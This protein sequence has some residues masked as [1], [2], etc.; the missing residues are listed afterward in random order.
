MT[1]EDLEVI[2]GEKKVSLYKEKIWKNLFLYIYI[3]FFLVGN[4]SKIQFSKESSWHFVRQQVTRETY[5]MLSHRDLFCYSSQNHRGTEIG[6][7]LW[8]SSIPTS[9]SGQGLAQQGCAQ[10]GCKY[11]QG[12]R[13]YHLFW[14]PFPVSDHTHREKKIFLMFKWIFLHFSLCLLFLHVP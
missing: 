12:W 5:I 2:T 1:K 3:I 8:R 14:Q 10:A 11:F 4:I 9:C 6:K 7:H 13:L